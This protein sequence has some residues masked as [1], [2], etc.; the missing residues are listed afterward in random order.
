MLSTDQ[1]IY[2]HTTSEQKVDVSAT[3]FPTSS[4]R[5]PASPR[6]AGVA[7]VVSFYNAQCGT[8][9]DSNGDFA[10]YTAPT[11]SPIETLMFAQ[12]NLRWGQIFPAN[13]TPIPDS[14]CLKDNSAIDVNGASV[15]AYHQLAVRDD[16]TISE[17]LYDVANATL[18]VTATSSDKVVPPTLTLAGYGPFTNGSIFLGGMTAPPPR[19]S[20]ISSAR[21]ANSLNVISTGAP[22]VTAVVVASNDSVNIIEDSGL[23]AISVINGDTLNGTQ[24]NPS[25]TPITLTIIG[26]TTKGS[27]TI[28]NA[29]GVI[30][31]KPNLNANGTDSFT[32][33]VTVNGVTSNIATALIN[34]APVN[35]VPI[36]NPDMASGAVN[37]PLI[38]DVLANDTDVDGDVLSIVPLSLTALSSPPGS[39]FTA[40]V[41]ANNMIAFTGNGVG[42]YQFRY[43]ATDGS[44]Q[45]AQ[46]PVI[47]INLSSP[48]AVNATSVQYVASKGRWKVSGTT[49]IA[50]AHNMTLSF[51]GSCNANGRFIGTTSSAA[52][53]FT[54]DL[55]TAVGGPLDSRTTNCNAVRVD[56]TLGGSDLTT[57]ITI[58]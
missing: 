12:G 41:N 42:A 9:L 19:V 48:E 33:T 15:P 45:S 58:K 20:V 3:A 53:A 35:D 46:S 47:T 14:I 26:G 43:L 32:Y 17:A 11:G 27:T 40:T 18:S 37:T 29:T 52:G 57:P 50:A 8:T 13:G 54:F 28:N 44:A 31:Y 51:T 36:A 34:I 5:I 49:S 38:I 24:I 7:P 22:V 55:N 23:I 10:G 1:A 21:G 4:S 56:S 2:S 25:A 6:P 39:T 16:I 30:S